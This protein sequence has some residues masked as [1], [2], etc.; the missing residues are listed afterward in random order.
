MNSSITNAVV[1]ALFTATAFAQWPDF[2]GKGLPRN[3]QGAVNMN[4]PTPKASDGNPDL[5]GIWNALPLAGGS[6]GIGGAVGAPTLVFRNLDAAIP[7]G[8]PVLPW[9]AQ[10]KKQ[11]LAKAGADSPDAHCLPVHPVMLHSHPQPRKV[12]QTP[13]VIIIIYE[14]N[15]GLRQIFTDGRPLPANNPQP[16]WYG[17]SVGKWQGDTLVVETNG[18]R[19][20]QWLDEAGTPMTENCKLTER[21]RRVNTGTLEIEMTIEDSKTFTKPFNLK[22]TQHLMPNTDL[23]EFVCQ[24]NEKSAKH[25]Q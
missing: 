6:Q 13:G 22:I 11:R 5:S 17:Y 23:I 1:A 9:A 8:V 16:W 21:F 20:D 15:S 7:G 14:A 25:Y 10:L 12:I 2:P 19:D 24:E 18:F 4:A 3:A